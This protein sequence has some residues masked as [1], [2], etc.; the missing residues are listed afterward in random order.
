[1][2]AILVLCLLL[3][4]CNQNLIPA[5]VF[6]VAPEFQQYYYYFVSSAAAQGT[7]LIIDNLVIRFDNLSN[8]H[9][10]ECRDGDHG[11]RG[12]PTISIDRVS[13]D[14]ESDL[15]RMVTI[16]HEMGHC[17]LWRD[18]VATYQDDN[19]VYYVTSIMYPYQQVDSMFRD[20]WSY[21]LHEMFHGR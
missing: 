14:S 21:Y 12:T 8:G 18:H 2:R 6:N 10:G 5:K 4:G 1:M 20:H 7:P 19:G 15:A 17:V 3:T 16:F 9:I 11:V 13:W